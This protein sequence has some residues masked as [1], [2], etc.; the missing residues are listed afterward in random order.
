MFLVQLCETLMFLVILI[1]KSFD[2]GLKPLLL[3]HVFDMAEQT[4]G[5]SLAKRGSRPR[6]A[7]K[8]VLYSSTTGFAKKNTLKNIISISPYEFHLMF[9][10][11]LGGVVATILGLARL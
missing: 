9:L 3:L 5:W 6:L 11:I 8:F 2:I 4:V 7:F 1:K 10:S